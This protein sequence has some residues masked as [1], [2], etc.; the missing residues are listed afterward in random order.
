[1]NNKSFTKKIKKM[2][3]LITLILLTFC[4]AFT[5][6]SN[7]QCITPANPAAGY[8]SDVTTFTWDAVPG[9]VSYRVQLIQSET[10][11]PAMPT[12]KLVEC[13]N[14]NEVMNPP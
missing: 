14:A 12:L 10:V 1:M 2:K 7:A 8:N 13:V 3:K 6:R 4:I 5:E 11:P 9:A